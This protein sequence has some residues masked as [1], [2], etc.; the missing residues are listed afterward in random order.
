MFGPKTAAFLEWLTQ[1]NVDISPKVKVDDLRSSGQGRALVAVENLAED[2]ELFKIPRTVL[3][4]AHNCSLVTDHPET[5]EQL[6]DLNQWEALLVVFLY[7]LNVKG[8]ESPWWPYL[9]VLPLNDTESY[10]FNQLMFWSDEEISQLE[11]SLVTGRVGRESA[12]EMFNKLK[13][14]TDKFF[15]TDFTMDDFT[16]VATVIMSYSFDVENEKADGDDEEDEEDDDELSDEDE[17]IRDAN[18]LKCMVPLADTL[19]ADTKKHNASLMYTSKVLVMK[20]IKPINKG[21][22]IYNTYSDHPNGE[23]LRRYGYVE[24]EGS[25]HDFGEIPLSVITK[26]FA[27][28]TS[29]STTI[30]EEVLAVLREVELEEGVRFV[31]DSFDFFVSG[32]VLFEATFLI[33]YLCI[34]A[35]INDRKSFSSA[36]MEVKGRG[37]RRVYKK[38]YQLLEMKKLTSDFFKNYSNIIKLRLNQYPKSASKDFPPLSSSPTRLQLAT[39]VLVSE[40]RSLLRC[41]DVDKVYKTGSNAYEVIDSDKILRNIMK[42]DVFEDSQSLPTKRRKTE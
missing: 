14:L 26:Y 12:K 28:N 27:E 33:Q 4:S 9:E 25:A 40:Y 30:I 3:L 8:P 31:L 39:S 6:L 32:D 7:E 29:L 34:I 20:S 42:K 23:I 18:Y 35:A 13:S 36:S 37:A 19:N 5:K 16:K 24:A 22:Q 41:Q 11:P 1:Q 2:E 10:T 21:Q 15:L 17:Q 38:C